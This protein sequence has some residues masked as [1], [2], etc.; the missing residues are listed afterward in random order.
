MVG[1]TLFLLGMISGI[2]LLSLLD[3]ISDRIID[4][5]RK[6]DNDI[7]AVKEDIGRLNN[8]LEKR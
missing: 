5:C 3:W 2:G 1:L 8:A 4:R 7:K 6:V